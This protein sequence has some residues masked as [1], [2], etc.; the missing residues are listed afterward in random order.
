[1][2]VHSWAPEMVQRWRTSKRRGLF[3]RLSAIVVALLAWEVYA[4]TQPPYLFPPVEAIARTGLTQFQE[5][6]LVRMFANSMMT[7]FA[8]FLLA[9]LAGITLG[10]A[11][12]LNTYLDVMV[13][14]YVNAFYVAP[15][16]ALVPLFI[17]IGGT[18][19][20]VRVLIVFLFAFFEIT[21]DTYE[22][23]ASTPNDLLEVS[24]SYG[25]G[26]TFII[27]HVVIPHDLPYIVA[28]LRLGLGRGIQGM[29]LAEILIEFV[30]LGGIIRLYAN[31]F[32]IAGVL[33]V[34]LVLMATSIVLTR[35]LQL[36]EAH[37]LKWNPEV[38]L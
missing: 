7:M 30:N 2:P 17:L 23:V 1:M 4:S 3:I 27:R 10:L 38:D 19:W 37:F 6:Q 12:G 29:I 9:A 20:E 14:P 28:G 32:Q 11:M 26:R 24:H 13:N 35:G 18:T 25:A 22:G 34:V 31:A 36:L 5:D 8:G 16:S 15:I 33:S 21:I